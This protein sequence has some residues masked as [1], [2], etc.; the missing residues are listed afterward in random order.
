MGQLSKTNAT[1]YPLL[2][3]NFPVKKRIF[4]HLATSRLPS[5]TAPLPF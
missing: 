5:F 3:R 4:V 1:P 2:E